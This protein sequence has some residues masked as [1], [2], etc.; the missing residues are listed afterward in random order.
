MI[1]DPIANLLLPESLPKV[2]ADWAVYQ[3]KGRAVIRRGFLKRQPRLRAWWNISRRYKWNRSA[4]SREKYARI[5]LF[6]AIMHPFQTRRTTRT[7]GTISFQRR[8]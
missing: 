1:K 2:T 4:L 5:H 6:D 7:N 8:Y 3:E